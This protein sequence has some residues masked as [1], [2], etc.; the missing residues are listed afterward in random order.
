L[1]LLCFEIV[2]ALILE[3]RMGDARQEV[4]RPGG[5]G[6]TIRNEHAFLIACV[7]AG[8]HY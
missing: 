7:E 1:V 5:W 4:S 6:F 2:F 8:C 3:G